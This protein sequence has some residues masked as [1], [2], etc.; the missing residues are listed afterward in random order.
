MKK[1]KGPLS[2]ASMLESI[3]EEAQN[4]QGVLSCGMSSNAQPPV[5]KRSNIN[6]VSS[7]FRMERDLLK[8]ELQ[9]ISYNSGKVIRS[10]NELSMKSNFSKSNE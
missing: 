5:Q 1:H 10:Y 8:S 4:S 6:Q 9:Q 3:D 2:M 7:Q